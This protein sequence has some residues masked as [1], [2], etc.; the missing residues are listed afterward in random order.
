MATTDDHMLA[1]LRRQAEAMVGPEALPRADDGEP[2]FDEPWQGRAVAVAVETIASLGLSWEEF[3]SRLID[4]IGD[5]PHRDYYE[6]WLVAL[7]A[8]VAEHQLAAAADLDRHRMTAAS[9]RTTE[10]TID[11]LEV[12]PIAAEDAVLLDVL[13]ELGV[14]GR[15]DLTRR[16]AH[17]ELQRQWVDGAVTT[18]MFRMFDG[19]GE[20]MTTV[21]LPNPFLADDGSLLDEPDWSRL[22]LWD[23]LRERCL[24]LPPDEA[25]RGGRPPLS[26]TR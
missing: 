21:L 16:C 14:D 1:D 6:S 17:A 18:W 9:Y 4:A 24:G 8:L 23:R 3:R 10:D 22:E 13:T 5:D 25:D 20:Q 19:D 26:V 7:E 15:A 2:V 12:F 11:D